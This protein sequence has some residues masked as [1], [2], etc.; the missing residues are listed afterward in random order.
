MLG[1]SAYHRLWKLSLSEAVVERPPGTYPSRNSGSGR[2]EAAAGGPAPPRDL[3][4][5]HKLDRRLNLSAARQVL[6][7][8]TCEGTAQPY[9]D[10]A[11]MSMLA[12]LGLALSP[13]TPA[14][15]PGGA[16]AAAAAAA[17]GRGSSGGSRRS[18]RR[19]RPGHVV[20]LVA[21]DTRVGKLA[22]QMDR[23]D[24]PEG[25]GV[26]GVG[27]SQ[28]RRCERDRVLGHGSG[29]SE[30]GFGHSGQEGESPGFWPRGRCWRK[31]FLAITLRPVKSAWL[32]RQRPF[33]NNACT[34]YPIL[35]QGSL[36]ALIV[37]KRKQIKSRL[38]GAKKVVGPFS[39][40]AYMH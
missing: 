12:S 25:L 26:D 27:D 9:E 23:R 3:F 18:R 1:Y 33:F 36:T 17:G 32:L 21:P 22:G 5:N 30:D 19:S 7:F 2:E 28:W 14:A 4:H 6:D 40:F 34:E 38:P 37:R 10:S 29:R 13:P 15:P 20:C 39:L 24:G 11:D 16:A 8:M 31:V 35:H